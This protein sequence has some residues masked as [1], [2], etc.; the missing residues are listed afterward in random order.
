MLSFFNE[1]LAFDAICARLSCSADLRAPR[2]RL[3]ALRG[4]DECRHD[5][6]ADREQHGLQDMRA[7]V[8]EP[9]Q[10]RKRPAAGERRAEHLG[11]DQ[12]GRADDGDDG[13][14]DDLAAAGRGGLRTHGLYPVWGRNLPEKCSAIKRKRLKK[15]PSRDISSSIYSGRKRELLMSETQETAVTSEPPVNPL[16]QAWQTPFET[17]PFAEISPEHFLPAF[18]QAFADHAAEVA[19]ITPDPSAPDFANT[20]PA[21]ARSRKLHSK[22]PT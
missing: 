15:A 21:L 9:E 13:R 18:E 10:D 5:E 6:D 17:P 4:T 8:V 22:V 1:A 20:D 2:K 12:D 11:A 14:P 19:A 16:L 7:G 3:D